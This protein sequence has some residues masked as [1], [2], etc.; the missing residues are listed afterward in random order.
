MAVEVSAGEFSGPFDLLLH[1]I[2]ADEVDI[3]DVSI[4]DIIEKFVATVEE[5]QRQDAALDLESLTE[6]VLVAATL[7]ELKTRRLLPGREA[8]DLDDELMRFE[9]RDLLLARLVDCKT[10]QTV[11]AWFEDRMRGADQCIPRQMGVEEPFAS[12]SVDPLEGLDPQLLGAAAA[13]AFTPRPVPEVSIAHL[14]PI[15]FT[16]RDTATHILEQLVVGER[17]SFRSLVAD[18]EDRIERIVYFLAV[19]ELYKQGAIELDQASHFGD[20]EIL[21]TT[22]RIDLSQDAFD[23]W[24]DTQIEDDWDLDDQLLSAMANGESTSDV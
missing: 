14:S 5:W 7:I 13:R 17:T 4:S 21:P 24:N 1:L 15:R 6:F 23:D 16:V 12:L 3:F 10:F 8:V 9:E 18:V 20:L 19:L 2:L 11:S 22:V